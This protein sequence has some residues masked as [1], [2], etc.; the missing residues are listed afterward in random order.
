M[1]K[2]RTQINL[3]ICVVFQK[4]IWSSIKPQITN[5]IQIGVIGIEKSL[6]QTV[7]SY[8]VL[9]CMCIVCAGRGDLDE[10]LHPEREPRWKKFVYKP[11][12]SEYAAYAY[13]QRSLSLSKND[14]ED[15]DDEDAQP[16]Q[17][18][19][20]SSP[21][22]SIGTQTPLRQRSVTFSD[23]SRTGARPKE[24]RSSVVL[25]TKKKGR[26]RKPVAS[27][28]DEDQTYSPTNAIRKQNHTEYL[29]SPCTS[30]YK[31]PTTPQHTQWGGSLRTKVLTHKPPA[32]KFTS[33]IVNVIAVRDTASSPIV[34]KERSASLDHKPVA[35][36][37]IRLLKESQYAA[38]TRI[39]PRDRSAG[40]GVGHRYEYVDQTRPREL[41]YAADRRIKPRD[42]SA[43]VGHSYE[44]VDQTLSRELQ[45][46]GDRRIKPRDQ[47][48]GAKDELRY[49]QTDLRRLKYADRRASS[50]PSH[51]QLPSPEPS[52]PLTL[53]ELKELRRTKDEYCE[54][55]HLYSQNRSY[56]ATAPIQSRDALNTDVDLSPRIRCM[57]R[58]R[59]PSSPSLTTFARC[60]TNCG[61]LPIT[62]SIIP[63]F[64]YTRHWRTFRD[65]QGNRVDRV[66][67][68]LRTTDPV[69]SE[70]FYRRLEADAEAAAEAVAEAEAAAEAEGRIKFYLH[71]SHI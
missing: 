43:S 19:S 64:F 10:A 3:S 21:H 29:K 24:R 38:D 25:T 50:S 2:K 70:Q 20:K 46:A 57:P 14:A 30:V 8:K 48:A 58:S 41:P 45:Y 28:S 61:D 35:E 52:E 59:A 16:A 15:D 51:R 42:R 18:L 66:L 33:Y 47:S 9:I 5:L 63:D 17:S 6:P 31:H 68:P 12:P 69:L 60:W 62:S 67:V 55:L 4:S 7:C 71:S 27:T 65:S 54:R 37:L 36:D 44:Y 13:R 22:L 26:D 39:K 11:P 40:A 53:Q 32:E 56:I 49:E 1:K 23:S 34:V